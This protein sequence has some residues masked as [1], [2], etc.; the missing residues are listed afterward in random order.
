MIDIFAALDA[1]IERLE[2]PATPQI[3]TDTTRTTG[4]IED[5]RQTSRSARDG[6]PSGGATDTL[7]RLINKGL[8]VL[9]VVPV[10]DRRDRWES[11]LPKTNNGNV[12]QSENREKKSPTIS[13]TEN[14]KI[15]G[16][17]GSI[18]SS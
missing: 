2:R 17:T 4:S 18:E 9:P 6:A 16:S 3:S 14:R 5:F 12:P 8:P 11:E 10:P 15:T 13:F 7:N 1:A